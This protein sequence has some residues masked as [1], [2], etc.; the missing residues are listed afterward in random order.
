[1]QSSE[2]VF[3][4]DLPKWRVDQKTELHDGKEPYVKLGRLCVVKEARGGKVAGLLITEAL[5]WAGENAGFCAGGDE[6]R[7]WR[8]L[9][10]VHAYDKAASTWARNGF[11]EDKGL[12]AWFEA[13]LRHVGMFCRV[14]V[15]SEKAM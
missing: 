10:C 8:G 13:G 14:P 7:E 15:Q 11:V 9:V 6:E 2:D 12:G 5:R 4:A 3:L 1:M